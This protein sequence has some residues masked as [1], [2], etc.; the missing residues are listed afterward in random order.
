MMYTYTN[1][2]FFISLGLVLYRCNEFFH[3]K[4]P[5]EL[6]LLLYVLLLPVMLF[7]SIVLIEYALVCSVFIV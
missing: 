7:K 4:S 1:Y 6:V 2:Y 3:I 5:I